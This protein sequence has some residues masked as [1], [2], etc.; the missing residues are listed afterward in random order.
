MTIKWSELSKKAKTW[1][2]V[3]TTGVVA[4]GLGLGLGLGLSGGS[5][6]PSY[7]YA[8]DF[9]LDEYV[10]EQYWNPYFDSEIYDGGNFVSNSTHSIETYTHFASTYD[11]W[12]NSVYFTE[13]N[14]YLDETTYFDTNTTST[15]ESYA[16]E[17]VIYQFNEHKDSIF[18]VKNAQINS[19]I[20][21]FN[22]SINIEMDLNEALS[23]WFSKPIN[24]ETEVDIVF[25]Y[26]NLNSFDINNNH[27]GSQETWMIIIY[28]GDYN[29]AIPMQISQDEFNYFIYDELNIDQA[30]IEFME[31]I[32]KPEYQFIMEPNN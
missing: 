22:S 4:L 30:L 25:K 12:G 16:E 29:N 8:D 11:Q 20:D 17:T 28:Y 2:I 9:Y 26:V 13:N 23:F 19:S 31:W 18:Y 24:D 21:S 15:Y 32:V 10:P 27:H 6:A 7:K 3:G 14:H 1:T 5:S